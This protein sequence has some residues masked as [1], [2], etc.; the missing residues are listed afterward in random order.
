MKMTYI[1]VSRWTAKFT[2]AVALV[3]V[4]ATAQDLVLYKAQPNGKMKID[5]T[6]TVHDWT[7]ESGIIGG[8]FEI[9][10]KF[11]ADPEVKTPP[12]KGKVNAKAAITIP[13]S[14][15]KSGSNPMDQVVRQAMKMEE[16]PKISFT[17]KEFTFTGADDKTGAWKFDTKGE[18]A[19]SGVTKPASF[20]V[21]MDRVSKVRLKFSGTTKLKMTD[22]GIQPPAPKI[23]LGAISTG[24]EV[25]LSWD[26]VVA[27]PMDAK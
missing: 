16:H 24:D 8:S 9:D 27:K 5:G 23:A 18:L 1:T 7:V 3:A 11:P 14:S 12:A 25:T 6:S 22:F 20:E 10:P 4:S 21:T 19:I 15:L 17:L 13:I 2:L 26:W